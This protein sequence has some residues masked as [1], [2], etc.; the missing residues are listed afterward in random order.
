MLASKSICERFSA[1]PLAKDR[2]KYQRIRK[3][4]K[5]NATALAENGPDA[6]GSDKDE[7][8]YDAEAEDEDKLAAAQSPNKKY[9]AQAELEASR[10]LEY[11]RNNQILGAFSGWSPRSMVPAY[12]FLRLLHKNSLPAVKEISL[13]TATAQAELAEVRESKAEKARGR[14]EQQKARIA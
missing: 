8:Y 2:Q 5:D 14:A 6:W 10:K 7:M 1:K 9:D 4:T 11:Y 3:A 13:G 12:Q